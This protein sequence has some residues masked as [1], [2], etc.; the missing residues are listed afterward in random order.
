MFKSTYRDKTGWAQNADEIPL[1]AKNTH[2]YVCCDIVHGQ[3]IHSNARTIQKAINLAARNKNIFRFHY[4]SSAR[5]CLCLP[6]REQR[7]RQTQLRTYVLTDAD[8]QQSSQ[9][10]GFGV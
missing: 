6:V 8:W 3:P 2:I 4:V 9:R 5:Q 7:R 1:A 10:Y